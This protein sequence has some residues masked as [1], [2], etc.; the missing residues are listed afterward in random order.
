MDY[1]HLRV[2]KLGWADHPHHL[3]LDEVPVDLL[4]RS[5]RHPLDPL[6]LLQLL[7]NLFIVNHLIALR[8]SMNVELI[9][10]TRR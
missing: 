8:S 6:L 7:L 3:L 1:P 4:R 2:L 5:S 10:S 9:G